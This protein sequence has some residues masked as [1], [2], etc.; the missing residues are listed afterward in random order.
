ML[1]EE[2]MKR[3]VECIGLNDT[4][5]SAAQ[6]MLEAGV[7]FLPVCDQAQKAIGTI[8]D[9]DIAIRVVARGLPANAKMADIMTR[10]V[11]SCGPKDDIRKAERVMARNHKSRIVCLDEEGLLVGVISLSDIAERDRER[12]GDTLAE[13][14]EREVHV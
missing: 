10:E 3:Q 7:G 5:Q 13:V 12:V 1:C 8:T 11:I 14:S 9:R 6:R 4:A 2:I